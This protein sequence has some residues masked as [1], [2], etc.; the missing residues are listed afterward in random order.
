M[1]HCL[2][3]IKKKQK[4]IALQLRHENIKAGKR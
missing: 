2:K 1:T 4:G 3:V